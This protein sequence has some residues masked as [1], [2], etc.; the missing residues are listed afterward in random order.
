M[1]N[2][3][4]AVSHKRRENAMKRS[5]EEGEYRLSGEVEDSAMQSLR[6]SIIYSFRQ[7]QP[8]AAAAKCPV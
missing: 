4:E 8:A 5:E 1:G 6:L 3:E 7:E 2:A